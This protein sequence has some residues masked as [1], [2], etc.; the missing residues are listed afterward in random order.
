[1][2]RKK[3]LFGIAILAIS[4]LA[5]LTVASATAAPKA[6]GTI[7]VEMSSDVD[8]IDPQLS[9]YGETWKLEAITA[10]KLFNWPD[11]EGAA[12]AVATPEVAAGLP[13]ISKDGKTYT[14]TVK[15]TFKFSNGKAVTAKS[16]V[17]AFNRFANPKMQSTG[18]AFLTDV[19]K[20]AQDVVDGKAA[21]ISG[22]RAVGNKFIIQLTKPA[23]DF[24]ARLTMPFMQAIDPTLAGQIDANGISDYSSC[25]PY[26]FSAR[27]PN[28][29]ITLKKNTFYKGGR[30]A[31][32]DTIQVNIGNDVDVEFQN[33]EKGDT[34]Y[35]S[36]GIPPTEWKNVVDKYGL[37]KKNGRVQVRPL[38]DIAYIAMHHG[39]DLFKNNPK[40]AKAVNWAVDRQAF[41]AQGGYL[42]GKRTG[43][44]LPPGLLGYKPQGIYP[45]RV[46][47]NTVKTAKKLAAGNL[48]GG[49]AVMW[50]SNRG[51]APLRAQLI[52]YNLKQMGL[53]AEI[54][55]LPRAQQFTNAGNPKTAE[56]DLT[57]ERWGADYADPYDFINILLDGAQVT[58][59]QH[60]NYAYYNSAKFNKQ[61][62]AASLLVGA[63]R[64]TAYAAL[65]GNMMR[66]D[67]PWAPL[68][69]NNDR[70]F[71]SSRVGCIVI[72]EAHGSGP[73]L[74]TICI[75]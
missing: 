70:S 41:S 30:A 60:N 18:V 4:G 25:G 44:T 9:Y 62:T 14:F 15:N 64:G 66:E 73:L 57:I 24:I 2:L 75:K 11:K 32:A 1:V 17:D 39:R 34:D 37:N 3:R 21:T 19:V 45:L 40:L 33:V 26:Y 58:N 38:L 23:P 56:Y 36:G 10:C 47:A 6:G 67:P 59:P 42:A 55:L 5:M 48:R 53:D 7:V 68:I 16:F 22:V 72:N 51:T 12:G 71:M 28:R 49:K 43:Q 35:A 8:Y 69:N 29:S 46:T 54:K 63:K 74:N 27:T 61:M 13:V 20:G 65:D 52:Q 31:N 50:S